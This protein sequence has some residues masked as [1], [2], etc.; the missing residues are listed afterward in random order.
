M[1]TSAGPDSEDETEQ[2]GR[3]GAGATPLVL[4]LLSFLALGILVVGSI[5]FLIIGSHLWPRP[6]GFFRGTGAGP[7]ATTLISTLVVVYTFFV[8][9]YGALTPLV[10]GKEN[11][12]RWG[13]I[14]KGD[15]AFFR[16]SA[17]ILMTAAVVLDLIRVWNSTG[18]LYTTTMRYLPPPKVY[19]AAAEFTRYLA[20]NIAVLLFALIVGCWPERSPDHAESTTK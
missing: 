9:A 7:D 13:R 2:P 8:A 19:D 10:I 17:L 14:K 15:A 12:F 4:R 5:L 20:I 3:K 11:P 16:V 6:Y 18:D 1:T